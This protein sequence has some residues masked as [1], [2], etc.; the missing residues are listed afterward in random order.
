MKV[1]VQPLALAGVKLI[2]GHR[3][4]DSRGYFAETYVRRDFLANDIGFDFIQDNESCSRLPGTIRGLHFQ[5]PP[6][7]Q[8]KLVRVLRGRILDVVVDLRRSSPDFGRHLTVE[9]NE[10]NADQLLVPVGFAH[11]F[12]TLEPDTVVLYKVDNVYSSAHD[13]GVNWADPKLA[14]KWPVSATGAILS[15]KDRALPSLDELPVHFD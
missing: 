1:V 14:I 5:A 12:C 7:A 4:G 15:D 8:T 2:K 6:L 9:L 13:C 11:G 3:I 10:S